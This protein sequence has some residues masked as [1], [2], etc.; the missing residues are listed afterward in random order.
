LS[1]NWDDC[2]THTWEAEFH[3]GFHSTTP[4]AGAASAASCKPF[5]CPLVVNHG[6]IFAHQNLLIVSVR[7]ICFIVDWVFPHT[8]DLE[9]RTQTE[10]SIGRNSNEKSI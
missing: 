5:F 9:A 2:Y 1:S 10:R 8:A 7:Q 4:A 3:A 6:T